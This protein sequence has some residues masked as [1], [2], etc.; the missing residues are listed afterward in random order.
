MAITTPYVEVTGIPSGLQESDAKGGV[1]NSLGMAASL[2]HTI[3]DGTYLIDDISK[4]TGR[5]DVDYELP[6][7]RGSA[8][9]NAACIPPGKEDSASPGM[10]VD[11]SIGRTD[12]QDVSATQCW[13]HSRMLPVS[14][15][16]GVETLNSPTSSIPAMG[17]TEQ[18]RVHFRPITHWC[19]GSVGVIERAAGA[20]AR[21]DL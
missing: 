11:M 15:L 7:G 12:N 1:P 5:R 10:L 8:F 14:R 18:I 13:P 6:T 4:L 9:S 19:G 17:S 16:S 20:R 3:T 2:S 21:I